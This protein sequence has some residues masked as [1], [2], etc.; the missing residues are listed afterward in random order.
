MLKE[1]KFKSKRRGTRYKFGVRVANNYKEALKL[2]KENGNTYW[3][4]AI[5][6]ELSQILGYDTFKDMGIGAK[7]PTGF[8][9]INVHF[10]FDVK[11]T[12][13][14]KAR[15]VAG[16]H[17]TDLLRSVCKR[18]DVCKH[19]S[20]HLQTCNIC[21]HEVYPFATHLQTSRRFYKS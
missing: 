17:M 4:D 5:K 11:A 19:H 12:L 16:G 2:D 20:L 9:R 7:A 14:R 8:Q 10:V 13:Q 18:R 15:L 21:K 3:Q 1:A 6:L